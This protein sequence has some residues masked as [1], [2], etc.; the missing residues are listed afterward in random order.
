MTAP[1][2]FKNQIVLPGDRWT[3]INFTDYDFHVKKGRPLYIEPFTLIPGDTEV[4][5]LFC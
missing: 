2:L 5:L 1:P 4:H 3:P